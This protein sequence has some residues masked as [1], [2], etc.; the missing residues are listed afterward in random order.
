MGVRYSARDLALC[1]RY[2]R[3]DAPVIVHLNMSKMAPFLTK[4][5][6]YRN[7]FETGTSGGSLNRSL[8]VNWEDRLFNQLYHRASNHDRVKSVAR[9]VVGCVLANVPPGHLYCR[10]TVACRR[11]C[12]NPHMWA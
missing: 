11:C 4:D 7:Q 10:R 1:L 3:D 9:G 12:V 8:R 5:T 2:L 6:H